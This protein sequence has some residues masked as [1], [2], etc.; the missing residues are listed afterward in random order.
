MVE[1]EKEQL[2]ELLKEEG[3]QEL[4]ASVVDALVENFTE[5]VYRRG[6]SIIATGEVDDSFRI[7]LK[8]VAR[9]V[10]KLDG[11]DVTDGFGLPGTVIISFQSWFSGQPAFTRVEGCCLRNVVL[12][13]EKRR[14]MELMDIHPE[15]AK[16]YRGYL[17]HQLSGYEMRNAKING[18]TEERLRT[19]MIHRPEVM[20]TVPLQMIASYLQITP[21]YLSRLRRRIIKSDK[22]VGHE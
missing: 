2:V 5:E 3:G 7:I 14:F 9:T 21:Q 6:E 10:Y 17:E 20:K 11:K 16:W 22:Q 8:G 19:F 18:S 12:R 15:L 4:P 13:M 1:K